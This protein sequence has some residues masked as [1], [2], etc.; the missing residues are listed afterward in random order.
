MDDR[1]QQNQEAF[2][3]TAYEAMQRSYSPEELE[4]MDAVFEKI[5]SMIV[6]LKD[7]DQPIKLVIDP[8]DGTPQRAVDWNKIPFIDRNYTK[9][10]YMFDEN[11]EDDQQGETSGPKCIQIFYGYH[12]DNISD[13]RPINY[14]RRMQTYLKCSPYTYVIALKYIEKFITKID[15]LIGKED[16]SNVFNNI[17]FYR[18]FLAAIVVASKFLQD[19][20]CANN[21]YAEFGGVGLDELWKIEHQFLMI[22]NL[23]LDINLGVNLIAFNDYCTNLVKQYRI[24]RTREEAPM[25]ST[26]REET[27]IPKESSAP[28]QETPMSE[29]S[30]VTQETEGPKA[31]KSSIDDS[32][33]SCSLSYIMYP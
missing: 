8:E 25:P 6:I 21:F 9:I 31:G 19:H 26:T 3:V 2:T 32:Q 11:D 12:E 22:I 30:A 4:L 23:D 7:E 16:G 29:A 27:P 1:A 15:A 17:S 33:S 20:P 5:I 14:L 28:R 18:I 13:L 10:P 24:R